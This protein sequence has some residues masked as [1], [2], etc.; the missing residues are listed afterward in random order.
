[1][2]NMSLRA[3]EEA[4][5]RR[6]YP[7]RSGALGVSCMQ[8]DLLLAVQHIT[9]ASEYLWLKEKNNISIEDNI[10]TSNAMKFQKN[11]FQESIGKS[12]MFL[13]QATGAAGIDLFA[14]AKTEL[15]KN[16]MEIV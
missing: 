11:H 3:F 1:M 15:E 5:K 7:K 6:L 13:L 2:S 10:P 12:M 14:A 16:E 8:R 4:Q 9:V